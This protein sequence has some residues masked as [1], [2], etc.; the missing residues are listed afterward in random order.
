MNQIREAT[1]NDWQALQRLNTEDLGYHVS[2]EQI[3]RQL[4]KIL[5][6]KEQVV[7]IAEVS[8]EICGYVHIAS[9]ETLYFS[10]LKNVMGLAVAR[11]ER[12]K[13]IGTQLMNA[14]EHWAKNQGASGVRVNSGESRT[15][16]HHFYEGLGYQSKKSQKNFLKLL[17]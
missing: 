16:A 9:Y 7:L 12:G 13:K 4:A 3:K 1:V 5:A 10:S 15:G 14:A 2:E 6:D 17:D 11:E 8:S